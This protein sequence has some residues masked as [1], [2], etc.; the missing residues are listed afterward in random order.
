MK[1]KSLL[2]IGAIMMAIL[3]AACNSGTTEAENDEEGAAHDEGTEIMHDHD[4]PERTPADDED[5][6]EVHEDDA[7]RDVIDRGTAVDEDKEKREA[8]LEGGDVKETDSRRDVIGRGT[9]VEEKEEEKPAR[10]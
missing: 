10:R 1:V 2:Q 5:R 6:G 4:A 8:K 3:I 7:R 9:A